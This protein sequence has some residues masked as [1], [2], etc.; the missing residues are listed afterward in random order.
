MVG[1]P[2]YLSITFMSLFEPIHVSENG[3]KAH[4]VPFSKQVLIQNE[5]QLFTCVSN[6]A[7]AVQHLHSIGIIHNDIRWDN[8][9]ES[10][11]IHL[12]VDFDDAYYLADEISTCPPL[13]HFGADEHSPRS[14]Q[15]HRGEVDCWAIGRLLL[16]SRCRAISER[17]R[18]ASKFCQADDGGGN[19]IDKIVQL[20]NDIQI[21]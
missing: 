21:C 16:T 13:T 6:I 19:S 15:E 18:E 8:I 20:F 3:V 14:F 2:P 10:G 5:Q 9:M 12:L 1:A 7:R 4:F 17:T 11:G